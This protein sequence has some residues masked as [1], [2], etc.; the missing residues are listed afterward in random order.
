MRF[1]AAVLTTATACALLGCAATHT[2]EVRISPNSYQVG[3][4]KSE[5]A[6]PAVNEVLRLNPA[7]VMML[8]CRCTADGKIIEFERELRARSKAELQGIH[9]DM[10]CPV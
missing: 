3:E 8:L 7:K 2:V 6:T 9:T 1:V 5:L 4:L 10:A